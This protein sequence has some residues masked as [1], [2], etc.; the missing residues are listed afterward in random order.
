M[1]NLIENIELLIIKFVKN[2]NYQSIKFCQR[3]AKRYDEKKYTLLDVGAGSKQYQKY[4]KNIRY[5]SQDILQ[6][7]MNSIDFVCDI[8]KGIPQIKDE[9]VDIILSTQVLEHIQEPHKAFKEFN[10][11]LKK[12]G[13]LYITTNMAYEEHMIPFDYFRFT[14]YGLKYLGESTGFRVVSI[15][16]QGG[17][18]QV[19]FYLIVN[20]PIFFIKRNSP[21]YYLY[22]IV[23]SIPILLFGMITYALDFLDKEKRITINY[24][25]EYVK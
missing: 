14:K 2:V 16:A 10:R 4:F 6:N 17:V 21:L 5:L 25:C 13:K 9:S 23:F 19:I 1:T 20:L 7:N 8:N 18:F 24:E 3:I 12:G 22:L 11:I 15:R